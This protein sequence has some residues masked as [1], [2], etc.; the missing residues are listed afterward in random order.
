MNKLYL[1]LF[2]GFFNFG[3][4]F[5]DSLSLIKEQ[6]LIHHVQ[7]SV[8]KAET[9]SSQLIPEILALDGMSSDKVRHFLNNLCSLKGGRYLEIGCWKGSTWISAL[10]GNENSLENAVAIDNWS[11]FGGPEQVFLD[12]CYKF[13]KNTNYQYYSNDCFKLDIKNIFQKPINIY[14]YDGNHSAYSQELALTY[15]DTALDDL[16]ILV[17]D[18]WNWEKVKAGTFKA[19]AK[20]KYQVL[21]SCEMPAAYNGDK[22]N[23][24]NGLYIAVI[25]KQIFNS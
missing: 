21:Y 25:K 14:F 13:L 7:E 11:E 5:C 8:T 10:Y 20:L 22:L 16:F 2:L 18:D 9:A 3:S 1:F 12:N 24:W 19:I 6:K 4:L 23:W 15:Y 17:V